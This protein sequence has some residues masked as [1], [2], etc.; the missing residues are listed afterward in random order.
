MHRPVP[1]YLAALDQP[2]DEGIGVNERG[3]CRRPPEHWAPS[4]GLWR[5]PI[6]VIGGPT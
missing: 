1:E 5:A 3:D 6:P 4:V 2:V